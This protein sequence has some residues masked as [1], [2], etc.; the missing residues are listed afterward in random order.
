MLLHRNGKSINR[1]RP[2]MGPATR[3]FSP[4]Q[5]NSAYM[6]PYFFNGAFRGLSLLI[7]LRPR[8]LFV[9]FYFMGCGGICLVPWAK[10]K[11]RFTLL[12]GKK[13]ICPLPATGHLEA[14]QLRECLLS[15]RVVILIKKSSPSDFRTKTKQ[16]NAAKSLGFCDRK[17][18]SS[19]KDLS[20]G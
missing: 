7:G 1:Q 9:P 16:P 4:F 13:A 5:L 2:K 3:F 15:K 8:R 12:G 20:T 6:S 10:S 19:I 18:S 14:K 17:S 11:S